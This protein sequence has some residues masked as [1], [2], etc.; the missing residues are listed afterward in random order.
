MVAAHG[1]AKWIAANIRQRCVNHRLNMSPSKLNHNTSRPLPNTYWVVPGRLLAG[2]YPIGPDY[3]DARAR[4]ARFRESG[5]NY[6]ID[7]T[8][9]GEVPAYRH[10]LP[11]HSKHQRSAI[12]DTWVPK[13]PEQMQQLLWDIRTA[14]SLGRRVYVHCRAGIGRTGLVIGCYLA[15]EGGDG[16]AA[17]KELNRLWHQSERAQSWPT[18]PQTSAQADYI[19]NWL[20]LG[21]QLQPIAAAPKADS[22]HK[23]GSRRPRQ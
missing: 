7:L 8:E 18:V 15:E 17:L 2:E 20:K 1:S 6:F 3:T 23:T 11:L 16:K 19:R 5:V 4:L 10:L 14:L 22:A 9:E 12:A 21:K 13:N